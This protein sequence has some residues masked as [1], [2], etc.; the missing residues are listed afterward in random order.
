MGRSGQPL[1][2]ECRASQPE[3]IKYVLLAKDA[4]TQARDA[5]DE[6]RS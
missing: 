5:L 3:R 4:E 1:S 6:E 2:P